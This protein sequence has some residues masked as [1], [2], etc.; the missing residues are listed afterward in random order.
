MWWHALAGAFLERGTEA[1]MVV[2]LRVLQVIHR[3]YY[4]MNGV[5]VVEENV[6]AALKRM[7]IPFRE[8]T[9]FVTDPKRRHFGTVSASLSSARAQVICPRNS[10]SFTTLAPADV[11]Y[12]PDV[13]SPDRSTNA[14]SDRI[15]EYFD[16]TSIKKSRSIFTNTRYMSGIISHRYKVPMDEIYIFPLPVDGSFSPSAQTRNNEIVSVLN[17]GRLTKRRLRLLEV[18]A[19][20]RRVNM[21]R[22][23]TLY[24]AG[25]QSEYDS[26]LV[27]SCNRSGVEYVN[28]GHA[29]KQSLVDYYRKVD[30]YIYLSDHEG[31]SITPKEALAC[32][33]PALIS[34]NPVHDEIYSG[35]KG[36]IWFDGLDSVRQAS[37]TPHSPTYGD[38][39]HDYSY[40]KLTTELVNLCGK[41]S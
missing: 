24:H 39:V 29:S 4:F 36:V 8:R 30:F 7:N 1:S 5:R 41:L 38:W 6:M 31:Y 37:E 25:P 17:V 33:T 19:L 40:E 21:N 11:L 26:M 28:L 35:K 34:H 2:L 15:L 12:V 27:D 13:G 23:V 18:P 3:K 32:G 9:I 14:V 20:L 10:I 22:N 16:S